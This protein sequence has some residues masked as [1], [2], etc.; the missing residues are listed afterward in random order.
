MRQFN[1]F[2][3]TKGFLS[4][5][6]YALKWSHMRNKQEAS[7][8]A[9]ALSFWQN[10]GLQATM[11]AFGVSRRTLYRWKKALWCGQGKL[12]ALDPKSTA[13]RN[14]RKRRYDPEYIEKAIRIR[15]DYGKV[16]KKKIA[17]ML[18]VSESYAGRTLTHLKERSLLP[19]DAKLSLNGRTGK[20]HERRMIRIKR[21]RRKN[22]QGIEI[23]AIV[24]FVNGTKRYILTAVDAQKKFAFAYAYANR[25]SLSSRDFLNKLITVTPF[26]VR[27]IQT[28]NGSEFA[29]CFHESCEKMGIVH[30]HIYPRSPKMNARIER[31][32]RTLSE[33]FV[34]RNRTLLAADID[35]FNRKLID[36][37]LW[38]NGER[39]HQSL[40][41]LSPLQFIVRE[42]ELSAQECQMWWT[43]T[44]S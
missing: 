8:R 24:R 12:A 40:G 3:G 25:F 13:P 38:Y 9:K 20:L 7:R 18:G 14:K 31:F 42:M 10:H 21:K 32:N 2:R 6:E 16:G 26:D 35:E 4:L 11:D 1:K 30:Y 37:L 15:K 22:K 29:S 43:S 28:D 5:Y 39:P 33:G 41:M 19:Q 27:E 36:W 17:A 23:D 44:W 34:M